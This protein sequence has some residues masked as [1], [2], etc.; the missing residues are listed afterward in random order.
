MAEKGQELPGAWDSTYLSPE[1]PE[2]GA[3]RI[4]WGQ[5]GSQGPATSH[6]PAWNCQ[7]EVSI[8]GWQDPG[9]TTITQETPW[10]W[11]P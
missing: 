8:N 6:E 4:D 3:G 7:L 11:A 10:E 9:E 5:G 2:P 1:A